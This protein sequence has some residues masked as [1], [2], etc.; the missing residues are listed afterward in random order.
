[1]KVHLKLFHCSCGNYY[2]L[3]AS[4]CNNDS[5]DD[6]G[7]SDFQLDSNERDTELDCDFIPIFHH[8]SFVNGNELA[9]TLFTHNV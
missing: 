9:Q 2:C 5:S 1:M 7:D 3:Y 4:D 8:V 6:S